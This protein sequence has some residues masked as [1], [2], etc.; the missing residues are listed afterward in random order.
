MFCRHWVYHIN[1]LVCLLYS[2][3]ARCGFS[4]I[5]G[6]RELMFILGDL[7]WHLYFMRACVGEEMSYLNSSC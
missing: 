7:N 6:K 1:I 4:K 3:T 5:T 2:V